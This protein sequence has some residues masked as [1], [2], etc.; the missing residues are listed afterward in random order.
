MIIYTGRDKLLIEGKRLLFAKLI[1]YGY[2]IKISL[3][4]GDPELFLE[5]KVF[6]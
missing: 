5:D 3:A 4:K 6:I 2:I 1:L